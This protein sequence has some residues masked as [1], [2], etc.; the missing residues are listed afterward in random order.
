MLLESAVHE[1][2]ILERFAKNRRLCVALLLKR[3]N[4]VIN[5]NNA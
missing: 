1:K 3:A 5:V 2:I 4:Y